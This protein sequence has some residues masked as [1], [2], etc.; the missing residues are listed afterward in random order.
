M[1]A[2]VDPER[3]TTRTLVA[4]ALVVLGAIVLFAG[5]LTLDGDAKGSLALVIGPSALLV[6]AGAALVR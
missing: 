2:P 6:A 1:D 5:L 3:P 4:C